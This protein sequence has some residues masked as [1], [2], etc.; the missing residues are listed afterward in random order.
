[1]T[2]VARLLGWPVH[3]IDSFALFGPYLLA[4]NPITPGL[5]TLFCALLL[6]ARAAP[7]RTEAWVAGLLVGSLVEI[8]LF[9]WA[10]VLAGLVATA[11]LRPPAG[12]A[13]R[14]AA[15]SRGGRA[16]L[17]ALGV[18]QA[19]SSRRAR[20]ASDVTGF[21]LCIGCLPRYLARAAWGDGELS[22]AIFRAGSALGPLPLLLGA[23]AALAIT[24]M[25]LGVRGFALPE[26]ARGWRSPDGAVVYRML[27]FASAA[28][29]V[30]AMTVGDPA[31]LPERGA[32][33]VGRGVR[34]RAASRDRVLALDRAGRWLPLALAVALAVPGALDTIAASRLWRSAA[35]LDLGAT[36]RSSAPR[37]RASRRRATSSSSRRCSSTPIVPSPIP[38]FAGRPVYL[39]LL[40]AVCNLPA[41]ERDARFARLVA[42]FA[43]ARR[44]A[45]RSARS[46]ESGAA[47]VSCRVPARMTP[48][49]APRRARRSNPSS[50]SQPE[51]LYRVHRLPLGSAP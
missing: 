48:V 38:L 6:L 51:Q 35:L 15:R 39:S 45:A 33:R 7:R 17:A 16:L 13:P 3:T 30:L 10:P 25:A 34:S 22:F 42:F 23:L 19:R 43:G 37:S 31:A 21:S 1:M 9:L 24:P 5:Q 12:A 20:R 29:L 28:G 18:R 41:A 32:V 49:A 14:A 8:K 27:G 26:L 46:R 11:L 2:A 44:D 47:F 50:Q 36:S 4:V 40:S